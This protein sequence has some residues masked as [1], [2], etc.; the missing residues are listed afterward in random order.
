MQ[1]LPNILSLFRMPLALM[2]LQQNVTLR[3][4]T[5]IIAM[6]TDFLDGFL[7]RRYAL[8]SAAGRFIDPLADKCFTLCVL[9]VLTA[10]HRLEL[11]ETIT[12]LSREFAV[13]L[14]AIYLLITGN[15]LKWEARSLFFGKITTALQLLL[16]FGLTYGIKFPSEVY[17]VFALLGVG[18]FCEL[19]AK[20]N[21]VTIGAKN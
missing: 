8:Q 5:L 18:A 7:A 19:I 21:Q 6:A 1:H 3:C 12:V 15:L 2:F 10:E 17:M 13:I 16:F 9:T 20:R 14:F 4:I 11:W